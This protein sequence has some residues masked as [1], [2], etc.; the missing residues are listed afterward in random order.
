MEAPNVSGDGC[1]FLMACGGIPQ[2]NICKSLTDG[3]TSTQLRTLS[4]PTVSDQVAPSLAYFDTSGQ[5][6]E[7]TWMHDPC[8]VPPPPAKLLHGPL[9]RRRLDGSYAGDKPWRLT[10][11]SCWPG[12][13]CPAVINHFDVD[14]GLGREKHVLLSSSPCSPVSSRSSSTARKAVGCGQP[15]LGCYRL[16]GSFALND[17]TTKLAKMSPG[18]PCGWSPSHH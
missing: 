5:G 4:D 8:M 18:T 3:C 7:E 1:S 14:W 2:S 16:T 10:R 13:G 9:Y 12:Q 17:A 11:R 15:V 6:V